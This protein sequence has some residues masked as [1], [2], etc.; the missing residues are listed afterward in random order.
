MADLFTDLKE[1]Y[2]HLFT[3]DYVARD[4]FKLKAKTKDFTGE[5]ALSNGKTKLK[6]KLAFGMELND[7]KLDYT[8]TVK[9]SGDH[10]LE[11]KTDLSKFIPNT[12]S[13]DTFNW[14]S[15][16]QDWDFEANFENESIEKTKLRLDAKV[17]KG[18]DWSATLHSGRSICSG[19]SFAG[20]VNYDGKAK[21]FNNFNLG[22]HFTPNEWTKSWVT[23]THEGK[24]DSSYNP[25]RTGVLSWNQRFT[26]SAATILGFDYSLNLGDK[27]STTALGAHTTLSDGVEVRGKVNHQG[28]IEAA[29]K[30]EV[31]PNWKMT[32][33]TATHASHIS[34][35]QEA[36]FGISLEGK[37]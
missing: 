31:S 14:N 30:F 10:S 35:K 27:T 33:A 37:L 6:G 8:L 19:L 18:G 23:H 4:G 15:K 24:I 34:G 5:A 11:T 13:T 28:D 22:A 7:Q 36:D 16:T 2:N 32:L 21:E 12:T 3:D 25:I 29:A 17:E 9:S 26:A 1:D 20:D